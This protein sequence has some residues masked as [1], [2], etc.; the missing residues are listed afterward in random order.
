[1]GYNII[2]NVICNIK[3]N[4]ADSTQIKLYTYTEWLF[5][6]YEINYLMKKNK[7]IMI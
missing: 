7:I 4:N 5:I 3:L 2:E 6:W 1:M